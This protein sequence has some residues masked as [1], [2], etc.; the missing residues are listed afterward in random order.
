MQWWGSRTPCALAGTPRPFVGL[1]LGIAPP[2]VVLR[3]RTTRLSRHRCSHVRCRRSAI[4]S[5]FASL[6]VSTSHPRTVMRVG[7]HR[8]ERWGVAVASAPSILPSTL[9]RVI[10][11]PSP[12]P[13]RSPPRCGHPRGVLEVFRPYAAMRWGGTCAPIVNLCPGVLNTR[14][15]RIEGVH[16]ISPC[17][18]I[19]R[20]R[21]RA[22]GAS[23]G[24]R[25]LCRVSAR[26]VQASVGVRPLP[27]Q[28]WT[29][30]QA[31]R[32]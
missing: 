19:C 13:M 32:T 22:R 5:G 25:D 20:P 12:F 28:V 6:P 4:L 31:D 30:P 8:V 18:C 27:F 1:G 26:R 16:D 3:T 11:C 2:R 23:R 14:V 29:H 9:S 10:R 7:Y 21:T 15:H 17:G 24:Y